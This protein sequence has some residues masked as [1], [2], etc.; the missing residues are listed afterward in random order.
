MVAELRSRR[1]VLIY[2]AVES[3]IRK[4]D[5]ENAKVLRAEG[6]TG[7]DV[8]GKVA[9]VVAYSR[10]RSCNPEVAPVNSRHNKSL[11]SDYH[12]PRNS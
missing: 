11:Y 1:T 6:I 4:K 9:P 5:R 10:I 12:S 8:K 2:V 7:A 3:D